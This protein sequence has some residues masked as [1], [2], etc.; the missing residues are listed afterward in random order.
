MKILEL[1]HIPIFEQLQIEEALLRLSTEDVCLF[2]HGSPPAIVMG[3]SGNP[4]ELLYQEKLLSAPIPVIR[5]YSGG[6]TVVVDENTLFVSFLFQKE[7]HSFPAFPEKIMQWSSDLYQ[8]ALQ[9][10]SFAFREND[11]VIDQRKVGGNAQYIQR[12]R[13][14]HHTSFLYDFQEERMDYLKLPQKRPSYRKER[15]HTDFLTKL[16]PFFSTPSDFFGKIKHHL[17]TTYQATP[18]PLNTVEKLLKEPHR[19]TTTLI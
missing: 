15:S 11:Y 5:R 18:M 19:K 9:I 17:E 1:S 7:S 12:T 14:L 13:W 6:G 2:N 3:I 8:E 4:E 10:P 16:R